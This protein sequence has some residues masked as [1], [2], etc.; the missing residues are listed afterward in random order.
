MPVLVIPGRDGKLVLR[1]DAS[2]Y[3]MG[4]ALYQEDDDG[5][6]QSI[7][8]KSKSFA[9]PQ[10]K[11]ASHD[12]ECLV[13]LYSLDSFRHFLIGKEFDVQTDNSDLAQ[14]FTTVFV[15]SIVEYPVS[16]TPYDPNMPPEA[17]LSPCTLRLPLPPPKLDP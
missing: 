2:R 9:N 3:A 17:L 10:Q 6:L 4:C 12:R 11:L 15:P 14:I 13:L 5:F 7:E 16:T 1:T 8:F